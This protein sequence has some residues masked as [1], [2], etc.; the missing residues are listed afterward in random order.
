MVA[1]NT[2][3]HSNCQLQCVFKQGISLVISRARDERTVMQRAAQ[4]SYGKLTDSENSISSIIYQIMQP[5]SKAV[6]LHL[7]F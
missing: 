7:L 5:F 6:V 2:K 1:C 3:L 4:V